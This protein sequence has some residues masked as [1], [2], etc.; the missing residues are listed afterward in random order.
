[1]YYVELNCLIAVCQFSINEYYYYQSLTSFRPF[2]YPPRLPVNQTQTTANMI[3]RH[4]VLRHAFCFLT[5]TL[6]RW[7]RCTNLT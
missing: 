1:M 2:S 6:T 4:A 3:Y 5:L 7:P